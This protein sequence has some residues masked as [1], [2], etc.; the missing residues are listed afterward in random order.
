M[1]LNKFINSYQNVLTY[2]STRH[3]VMAEYLYDNL[4]LQLK[5]KGHVKEQGKHVL[6]PLTQKTSTFPLNKFLDSV[7]QVAVIFSHGA[8][9][10]PPNFYRANKFIRILKIMGDERYIPLKDHWKDVVR[11]N[12]KKKLII[13]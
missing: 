1:D 9:N 6:Q 4:P 10:I 7:H 8:D 5:K 13:S 12:K 2:L 11:E 3:P